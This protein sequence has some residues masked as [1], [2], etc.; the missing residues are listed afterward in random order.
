MTTIKHIERLEKR[1]DAFRAKMQSNELQVGFIN[2]ATYPE[3]G[4]SVAQVAFNNEFG[5]QDIPSR[6]FFRTIISSESPNWG[7]KLEG[8]IK[9]THHDLDKSMAMLGLDIEGALRQSINGWQT[10][11]NS[12]ATIERKGFNKPLIDSS[13]MVKSITSEV[14]T[15]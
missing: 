11:P 14:V 1:L 5:T 2:G 12:P 4:M 3:D 7:K 10:P 13:L 8:A 15:K 6:P 9:A